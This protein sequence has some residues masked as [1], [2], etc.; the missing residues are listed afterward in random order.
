L[1]SQEYIRQAKLDLFWL[2]HGEKE[3]KALSKLEIPYRNI[4][5]RP[6][7]SETFSAFENNIQEKHIKKVFNNYFWGVVGA[8]T[9]LQ[10]NISSYMF[11]FVG[12]SSMRGQVT[13][14][15]KILVE[16]FTHLGWHHKATIMYKI[17]SRRLFSYKVNPATGLKDT[18]TPV[19]N[20][21]ILERK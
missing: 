16:H 14:I 7:F 6:I 4:T 9:R 12:H 15:D 13:P 18:R 1:Q 19:E 10:E 20:L 2:G 21:V 17:V 3:V 8:L 5:P 11:L